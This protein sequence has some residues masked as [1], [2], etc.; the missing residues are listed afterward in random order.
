MQMTVAAAIG[1]RVKKENTSTEIFCR[2]LGRS[3]NDADP[4]PAQP[5]HARY[6]V[7][8]SGN[9]ALTQRKKCACVSLFCGIV[10]DVHDSINPVLSL[11]HRDIYCCALMT[12][13]CAWHY[14]RRNP[15]TASIMC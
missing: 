9:Q 5:Q 4:V 3:N 10:N 6:P 2:F 12:W 1:E 14:C 8:F 13:A 15:T 7:R 11:R